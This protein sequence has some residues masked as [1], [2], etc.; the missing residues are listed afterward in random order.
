[1]Y[2]GRQLSSSS[3][4]HLLGN[5]IHQFGGEDS[6]DSD[7]EGSEFSDIED[8]HDDYSEL[9]GSEDDEDVPAG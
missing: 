9:Y 3:A 6:D 5:Y 4:V 2:E 7:Y 8:D 1:M